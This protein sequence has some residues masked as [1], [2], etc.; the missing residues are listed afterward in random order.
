MRGNAK[1][2]NDRGIAAKIEYDANG[3]ITPVDG[4]CSNCGEWLV[5]SDE[6]AAIGN[7]CPCCGKYMGEVKRNDIQS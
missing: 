7:F 6:Y 1:W 5:G 3:N 2:L 4:Y